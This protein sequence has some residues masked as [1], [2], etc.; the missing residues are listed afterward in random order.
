[1]GAFGSPSVTTEDF[2]KINLAIPVPKKDFYK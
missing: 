1:M 2:F